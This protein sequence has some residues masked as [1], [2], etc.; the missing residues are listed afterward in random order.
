[1]VDLMLYCSFSFLSPSKHRE[2]RSMMRQASVNSQSSPHTGGTSKETAETSSDCIFSICK[3]TADQNKAGYCL[4]FK[5]ISNSNNALKCSLSLMKSCSPSCFRSPAYILSIIVLLLGLWTARSAIA[6]M[7]A[8]S[9]LSLKCWQGDRDQHAVSSKLRFNNL[10]IW[11][12]SWSCISCLNFSLEN[13]ILSL[14]SFIPYY[15]NWNLWLWQ[16]Q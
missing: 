6:Y 10:T 14:N 15:W 12:E 9:L 5:G 11:G 13:T 4:H 3:H 8:D 16:L 1:M 2:D 7:F